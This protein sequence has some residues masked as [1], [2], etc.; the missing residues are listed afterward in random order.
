MNE[1]N[2]DDNFENMAKKYK[3]ASGIYRLLSYESA[4]DV[5]K[6]LLVSF[7]KFYDVLSNTIDRVN[8]SNGS[9][10]INDDVPILHSFLSEVIDVIK[11][12]KIKLE[13]NNALR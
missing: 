1:I 6:L 8:K 13:N 4:N 10:S 12:H 2:K 9:A 7:E 5:F 3:L 11:R